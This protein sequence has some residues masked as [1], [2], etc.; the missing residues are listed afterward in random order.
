[1]VKSYEETEASKAK[2]DRQC[3]YNVTLQLVRATLVAV[4]KQNIL[5]VMSVC[6]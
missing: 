2:Q 3:T 5:H 1:L 6:L 4:E